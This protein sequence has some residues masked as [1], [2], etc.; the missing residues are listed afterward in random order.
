[1][2][3]A[4]RHRRN[5]IGC[6]R[7]RKLAASALVVIAFASALKFSAAS[8]FESAEHCSLSNVAVELAFD[9]VENQYPV[10]SLPDVQK[11]EWNETRRNLLSFEQ[12]TKKD[13]LE[14]YCF[15][16]PWREHS[17][18]T[19]IKLFLKTTLEK[20]HRKQPGSNPE[21]G[22]A[23]IPLS[24]G[25][26]VA[27]VDYTLNS[28]DLF[29]PGNGAHE[30]SPLS[31][32]DLNDDYF[33]KLSSLVLDNAT[34][35]NTDHFQNYALALFGRWHGEA[36][37]AA[38]VDEP[39]A[40][41][42]ALAFS[43]VADHFL[44]DSFAPGHDLTPRYGMYDPVALSWHDA[45][46][47]SGRELG[48]R[49]WGELDGERKDPHGVD[50]DDESTIVGYAHKYASRYDG[51][52]QQIGYSLR[53]KND[54]VPRTE[55][56]EA[57]HS[58]RNSEWTNTDESPT[59][60]ASQKWYDRHFLDPEEKAI[61]KR[62]DL[63][64]D[65]LENSNVISDKDSRSD[66]ISICVYGDGSLDQQHDLQTSGEVAKQKALMVVI[67]ARYIADV[68]TAYING[69]HAGGEGVVDYSY[70]W[71]PMMRKS[72]RKDD[73]CSEILD[74]AENS[75]KSSNDKPCHG[76]EIE[77]VYMLPTAVTHYFAF[78]STPGDQGLYKTYESRTFDYSD[79]L[80]SFHIGEI[81]G[82]GRN[83]AVMGAEIGQLMDIGGDSDF[84]D[85]GLQRTY[86]NWSS[87]FAE[88]YEWYNGKTNRPS[89]AITLRAMAVA[90]S[91]DLAFGA[92]NKFEFVDH[93]A[94]HVV[95]EAY[96]L[97]TDFGFSILS[98]Y[99]TAGAEPAF[100]AKN[101]TYRQVA[102]GAGVSVTINGRRLWNGLC[103][104]FR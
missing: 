92:Y 27:V 21:V 83:P 4:E 100:D 14:Q 16:E 81:A 45:F 47:A 3:L 53:K 62:L 23:L 101:R 72:S 29:V 79:S 61:L 51:A 11:A 6:A 104:P 44:E 57:I 22:E 49:N 46:N 5:A 63:D 39:G 34:H 1:V 15:A 89:S 80:Y 95:R 65:E 2:K 74:E 25:K 88:G 32:K 67:E 98:F 33:K 10:N 38:R 20:I 99:L 78:L 41:F 103:A 69:G 8:A 48:V 7:H 12:E 28:A 42:R 85:S 93:D 19:D 31:E 68:L 73:T 75:C 82:E 66:R 91:L 84:D 9:F 40:L 96:G 56:A 36:L 60:S 71:C 64:W 26:I 54:R 13:K 94:H 43:A 24:Y 55:I 59:C 102:I 58:L 37:R 90:P 35:N 97:R 30:D 52:F 18:A 17:V 76:R 77:Q 87:V 70:I 86:R 50:V